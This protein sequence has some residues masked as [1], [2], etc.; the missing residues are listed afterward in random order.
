MLAILSPAKS[1]N[2]DL[3]VDR[4]NSAAPQF[5]EQASDLVEIMR[6]FSPSDLAS[7]MKTI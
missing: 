2:T 7:L 4:S 5:L 6:G 3:K 1:L